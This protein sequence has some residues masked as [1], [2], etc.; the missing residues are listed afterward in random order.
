M[1]ARLG[2]VASVLGED[3]STSR[4]CRLRNATESRIRDLINEN[5]KALDAA[6]SF[7]DRHAIRLYRISSN[8]IPFASHDVNK[9]PWWDE[10]RPPTAADG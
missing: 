7:L 1:L 2:F 4:T 3:L 6:V 5:L 8:V 9:V 10:Y